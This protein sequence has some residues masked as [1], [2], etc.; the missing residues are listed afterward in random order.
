[1]R[2]VAVL[3]ATVGLSLA[4]AA[5]VYL[6]GVISDDMCSGDH[7]HMGGTDPMKCTAE[8]I[9]EMGAKYALI[10]GTDAYV[11]SDQSAAAKFSGQKVTVTGDVATSTQGKTTSKSLAVKSIAPAK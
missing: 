9:K 4:A 7:K 3:I 11:L 10:V 6:T 2:K 5:P 8:C 1:M